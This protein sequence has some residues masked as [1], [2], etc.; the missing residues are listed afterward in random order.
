MDPM[1]EYNHDIIPKLH[2]SKSKKPSIKF[3]AIIFLFNNKKYVEIS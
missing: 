1:T 2:H 3:Y